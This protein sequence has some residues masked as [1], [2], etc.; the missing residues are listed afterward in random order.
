MTKKV[1]MTFGRFQPPTIGHQKLIDKIVSYAHRIGAEGRVY[2]SK[3]Y[4][5]SKNPIPYT[6]KVKFLKKL[7]PHVNVVEHHAG[8]MF[9]IIKSLIDEGFDDITM[10]VGDDRVVLMRT[11]IGKYVKKSDRPGFDP[12]K[13]F[14]IKWTVISAGARDPDATGVVGASG[15]KVREFAA[16]GDFKS[17]IANVPTKNVMLAKTIFNTLKQNMKG[18]IKEAVRYT[19]INEGVNDPAIFKAVFLGGGPGSGKDFIMKQTLFGLGLVEINSDIAFEYLLKKNSLSLTMPD[20]EAEP[21]NMLRGRAKNITTDKSRLA[22]DG[23]LGIIINSTADN[24]NDIHIYK[25]NLEKIGYD[26]MMVFVNTSN[27]VS[28]FRN[29]M[30]G[31]M[32]GRTVPETIRLPKWQAAQQNLESFKK[33]FGWNKFHMVDNSTDT[34]H[35]ALTTQQQIKA[36]LDKVYKAT[37]K[38]VKE[39]IIKKSALNWIESQKRQ[40]STPIKE[41]FEA[42]RAARLRKIP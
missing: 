1:V 42:F 18:V 24:V 9:P 4:D 12:K 6:Q 29:I 15:T 28:H 3:S 27:E 10:V 16:K 25:K 32:G 38:F 30:R 20:S 11:S 35:A 2:T 23:R 22:I 21:R 41:N 13:H 34:T 17:F 33:F 40:K 8:Q 39:P 31:K 5:S 14:S 26:C 19:S 36:N 7:F 37:F